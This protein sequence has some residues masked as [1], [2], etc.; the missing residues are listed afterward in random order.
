MLQRAK[1]SDSTFASSEDGANIDFSIEDADS[2]T[3]SAASLHPDEFI[4]GYRGRLS[5]LNRFTSE[6]EFMAA[7]R[8]Q[9]H[10]EIIGEY[11]SAGT[12]ARTANIDLKDFVRAH[13]MLPL[14]RAVTPHDPQ[15]QHGDPARLDIIDFF[16]ARLFNQ[17]ARLCPKCVES[18][19]A[20]RGYSY[21]R[22]S[23]QLPGIYWCLTHGTELL[24][25]RGGR[26]GFRKMPHWVDTMP[27]R[28]TDEQIENSRNNPALQRYAAVLLGFQ[29]AERPVN[30]LHASYRIRQLAKERGIRIAIDGKK[31]T[32]SDIIQPL[33]PQDWLF[34]QYPAISE[35]SPGEYYGPVDNVTMVR[36]PVT[37]YALALAGLFESAEE[38][39]AYWYDDDLATPTE[40]KQ[41]RIFGHD[42]WSSKKLFDTYVEHAGNHTKIGESLQIA[43]SNTRDGLCK[44]G[45]P[46]LGTVDLNTLGQ[47]ILAYAD[48]ESL[49]NAC[50]Y[51]NAAT[52]DANAL[53]RTAI[54]PFVNALRAMMFDE[55][56][57]PKA[58]AAKTPTTNDDQILSPSLVA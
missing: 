38:A 35:R 42:F 24:I 25:A 46:A 21:W 22:C 41:Y 15:I 1:V 7:L 40:R 57:S 51:N 58:A 45:L 20:D 16:G 14:H 50:K 13:T 19:L 52:N 53:I 26:F 9:V 8:R 4:C 48:G 49:E 44:V 30:C 2:P 23:Q 56:V 55:T 33:F 32:L 27:K 54:S 29:S 11:P 28:Y 39:L 17:E 31:P 6:T 43:Q 12:L 18:D 10:P 36:T 47:A 37:A 3:L 34:Q 5:W